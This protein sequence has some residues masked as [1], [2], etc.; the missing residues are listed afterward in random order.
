MWQTNTPKYIHEIVSIVVN[1]VELLPQLWSHISRTLRARDCILG[2]YGSG[3]LEMTSMWHHRI[4]SSLHHWNTHHRISRTLRARDCI[5]GTY[6]SGLLDM[7]HHHYIIGLHHHDIIGIHIRIGF[8]LGCG[9]HL[10]EY[11][12][13]LPVYSDQPVFTGIRLLQVVQ[14]SC[15]QSQNFSSDH[16]HSVL[17][18]NAEEEGMHIGNYIIMTSLV[19]PPKV[20][21][22]ISTTGYRS[23]GRS[24]HLICG[25]DIQ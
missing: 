15:F 4:S 6:R 2:T 24:H 21:R 3:L 19:G 25:H 12:I 14:Y 11:I 1:C 17:R 16:I 23:T 20:L 13:F 22:R 10:L 9:C 18:K 5:L 7:T 8:V